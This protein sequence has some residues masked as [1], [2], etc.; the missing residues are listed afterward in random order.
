MRDE[1]PEQLLGVGG[2]YYFTLTPGD[3]SGHGA[4]EISYD[5]DWDDENAISSYSIPIHVV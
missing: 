1:N 2:T 5:R 4:F 3:K